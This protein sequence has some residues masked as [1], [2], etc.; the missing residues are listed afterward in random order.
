MSYRTVELAWVPRTIV[1]WATF[2]ASRHEA[3]RLWNAL[4]V[5]HHRLR[6]LG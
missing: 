2:G 3:A 1:D 5:R 6:R 4:V